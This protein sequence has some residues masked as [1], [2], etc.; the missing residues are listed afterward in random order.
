MRAETGGAVL[1]RRTRTNG[2]FLYRNGEEEGPFSLQELSSLH[3]RGD[4]PAAIPC[5]F[6]GER[7][8]HDL[9]FILKTAFV[10]EEEAPPAPV[11]GLPASPGAR[12]D[13]G[14]QQR[15][16]SFRELVV[17]LV[18]VNRR[19]NQLLASIKRSLLVLLLLLVAGAAVI[20]LR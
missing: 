18:A 3:E 9:G 11:P 16:E 17:E 8:W 20:V 4:V 6:P 13:A 5:R 10:D 7:E 14:S 19:Q 1:E 15:A 2:F 12:Q